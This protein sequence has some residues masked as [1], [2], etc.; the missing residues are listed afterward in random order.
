MQSTKEQMRERKASLIGIV[1]L[2]F[3]AVVYHLYK[4]AT[5]RPAFKYLGDT[6]ACLWTFL[7]LFLVT[8]FLQ[9]RFILDKTFVYSVFSSLVAMAIYWLISPSGRSKSLIA[10]VF[11][12]ACASHVLSFMYCLIEGSLFGLSVETFANLSEPIFVCWTLW[13]A[14]NKV[15]PE[16]ISKGYKVKEMIDK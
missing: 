15:D 6:Y 8:N 16:V 9:T 5:F 14:F 10:A 7:P 13:Y 11:M 4:T 3:G 1:F 12:S 2:W